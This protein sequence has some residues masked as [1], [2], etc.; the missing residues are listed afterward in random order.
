MNNSRI[1]WAGVLLA[2][3]AIAANPVRSPKDISGNGVPGWEP[4]PVP[5]VRGGEIWVAAYFTNALG[6]GLIIGNGTQE[7]P[8]TGDFDAIVGAAPQ[9][10]T[11]NVVQGLFYTKGRGSWHLKSNQRLFGAGE[12]VTVIERDPRWSFD[13]NQPVILGQGDNITVAYL[14]INAACTNG[15]LFA[16]ECLRIIGKSPHVSR[17]HG[18]RTSGNWARGL[19]CWSF[20]LITGET[21]PT[22]LVSDCWLSDVRGD[23]TEA[24]SASG[25]C[26]FENC[27][28]DFPISTNASVPPFYNGFQAAGFSTIVN[29][30][31]RG[32]TGFFYT[33]TES[34]NVRLSR[35]HGWELLQGVQVSV[36][37]NQL[38]EGLTIDG[39]TFEMSTNTSAGHYGVAVSRY[40]PDQGAIRNVRVLNSVFRYS[41]GVQGPTNNAGTFNAVAIIGAT[42]T[43]IAGNA[44]DGDMIVQAESGASTNGNTVTARGPLPSQLQ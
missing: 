21:I 6:T 22:G 3:I 40:P 24:F 43:V 11:I 14:T 35:C 37:P 9:G 29:C 31:Q 44:I 10:T 26:N 18:M 19:E 28:P 16:H 12:G 32:G 41:N 39:C 20:F 1:R 27:F 38:C 23:Y 17:V 34:I 15:E 25:A 5:L 42:G 2:I 30:R 8:Y 7:K 36:R 33:D 4:V 13:Q